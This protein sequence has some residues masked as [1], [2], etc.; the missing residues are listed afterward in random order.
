M[1]IEGKQV[2]LTQPDFARPPKLSGSRLMSSAALSQARRIGF[3]T[4][5]QAQHFLTQEFILR[6]SQIQD[7]EDFFYSMG[8]KWQTFW[9]LSWHQELVA[10]AGINSGAFNLQIS[11]VGYA[12]EYNP[13]DADTTKLGHYVFLLDIRGN[14]HISKVNSVSGTSPEILA[15]A[16]APAVTFV[17]GE[18]FIGFVYHVRFTSDELGL[19]YSGIDEAKT[20]LPMMEAITIS[21]S[22]DA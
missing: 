9:A 13:A 17:L 11:P 7:I 20:T 4:G 6:G 18:F 2:L 16:T 19:E 14:L 5:Q 1:I 21:S 22:P 3:Y 15:L 10:V 12:T 8:G